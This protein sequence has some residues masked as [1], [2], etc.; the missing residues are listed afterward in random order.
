MVAFLGVPRR[1]PTWL[2]APGAGV[3]GPRSPW[4]EPRLGGGVTRDRI[5]GVLE[6]VRDRLKAVLREVTESDGRIILVIDE[7]HT[8]VRASAAEGPMD[9]GNMFKPASH[10]ASSAASGPPPPW[11]SNASTSTSRCTS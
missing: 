1:Q 2:P 3:P 4:F 6:A 7:L 11:T 10:A 5:Y 8:V 9:A